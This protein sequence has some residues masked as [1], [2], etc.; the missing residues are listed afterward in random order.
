MGENYAYLGFAPH[1]LVF[2]KYVPFM[3][4]LG[5]K[6]SVI[7]LSLLKKIVMLGRLTGYFL[8]LRASVQTQGTFMIDCLSNSVTMI[9]EILEFFVLLYRLTDW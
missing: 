7:V 3:E 4:M 1:F 5:T 6:E 2:D 9:V 8:F